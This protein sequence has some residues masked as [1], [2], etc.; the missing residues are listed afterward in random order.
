MKAVAVLEPLSP[1]FHD[2]SG[3]FSCHNN[4]LFQMTAAVVRRKGFR[5]DEAAV[6]EQM[7]RTRVYLESW[8]ERELQDIP[9]PG[10]IDTTAYILAGLA[11]AHYQP[12]AATDALARYVKRRQFADG[13]WR[14]A[15]HRP[16]I[17][18][19]TSR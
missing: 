10:R 19:A 17:E 11:D 6:R 7:T 5:I 9:I 14:V 16:P 1:L 4:S 3:C 8:R 15:A 13:G 12:D 2:Q 18:S